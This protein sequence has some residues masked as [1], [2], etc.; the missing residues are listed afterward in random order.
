MM[1]VDVE[2]APLPGEPVGLPP[3]V[4]RLETQG[5][6]FALAPGSPENAKAG[7]HRAALLGPRR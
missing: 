2:R 7:Q 5:D 4:T 3:G 6:A 1:G